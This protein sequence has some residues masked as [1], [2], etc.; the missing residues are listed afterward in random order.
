MRMRRARKSGPVAPRTE[1]I[2]PVAGP[3]VT[4]VSPFTWAPAHPSGW[5]TP[6][7]TQRVG[8][9][10][11]A[12]PHLPLTDLDTGRN[13]VGETPSVAIIAR[14]VVTQPSVGVVDA[15]LCQARPVATENF[16]GELP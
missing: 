4:E 11:P 2:G 3:V 6:S 5:Q 9:P 12:A 7:T 10:R 13:V 8:A 16:D 15:Q 1:S 14:A